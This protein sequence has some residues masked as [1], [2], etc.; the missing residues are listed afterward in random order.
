MRTFTQHT[1]RETID[2]LLS[3]ANYA[4]ILSKNKNL[5]KDQVEIL[6]KFFKGDKDA[7]VHFER[8]YGFQSKY[9]KNMM[10]WEDFEE[11][12]LEFKSGRR[13][14]LKN[15]K[16][17]GKKGKD[18]WPIKVKDKGF[19]ANVPL[20]YE[21]AK[22]M[23]TCKYGTIN[24]N[25][26]IGW[27]FDKSYWEEHVIKNQKLPIYIVDGRGK[28]VVMILPDNKT[29]EVRDKMNNEDKAKI[30]AEPIPG[31]S[32][33]K[34]L[35]NS[36]MAKLYD[37][38]RE[39]I[40]DSTPLYSEEEYKEALKDYND[41][42]GDIAHDM[43]VIAE[44]YENWYSNFLA[45][46]QSII[47]RYEAAHEDMIEFAQKY[48]D[49][50]PAKAELYAKRADAIQEYIHEISTAE[51]VQQIKKITADFNKIYAGVMEFILTEPLYD[52]QEIPESEL[53]FSSIW[54]YGDYVNVMAHQGVD[55][56]NYEA[57]SKKIK[58]D[59]Q[60]DAI[61]SVVLHNKTPKRIAAV[62]IVLRH[63]ILSPGINDKY[64]E[65]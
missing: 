48:A 62:E 28:W 54:N 57:I 17:P 60:T 35:I 27:D 8:T 36:R 10:T 65:D 64:Y 53:Y 52:Y 23:N 47:D 42:I 45:D 5:T 6:D 20:N 30:N 51:N 32:I 11:Y 43:A 18:Y 46:Q 58:R 33:K 34:N 9:V 24:V 7:R 1:K 39:I 21:T 12:M 56:G 26:C 2:R 31:F 3:E 59:I 14:N 16:I 63:N 37:E 13:I 4:R 50:D 22:F 44:N 29:Y 40:N 55:V 19:I 61:T 49:T 15:I 25:F 41:M 38:L